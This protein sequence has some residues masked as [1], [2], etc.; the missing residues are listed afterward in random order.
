RARRRPQSPPYLLIWTLPASLPGLLFARQSY[1]NITSRSTDEPQ[2]QEGAFRRGT[3]DEPDHHDERD[4]READ[5]P[6]L[7][8]G[9]DDLPR[10]GGP[11]D[12]RTRRPQARARVR[13]GADGRPQARRVR[14]NADL[15]RSCR[16]QVDPGEASLTWPRPL[17]PP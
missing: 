7:V 14:A 8:A 1:G 11:H 10:H 16:R 9:V 2:F 4:R 5:D 13:D 6:H 15:P 17:T 12:C 3:A